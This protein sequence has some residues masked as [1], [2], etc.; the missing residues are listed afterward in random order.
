VALNG[1][2][3][4][5]LVALD[6]V[7]GATAAHVRRAADNRPVLRALAACALQAAA[8]ARRS[9]DRTSASGRTGLFAARPAQSRTALGA[10]P[11]GAGSVDAQL[12][13]HLAGARRRVQHRGSDAAHA[14]HLAS[15]L[16]LATNSQ[17]SS[18]TTGGARAAGRV[19][20]TPVQA[21]S[22]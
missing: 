12:A 17:R 9:A 15:A 20:A 7:H 3:L 13:E 5:S 11:S 19:V 18:P 4:A 14:L 21:A 8:D 6:A 1:R 10:G 2:L 16:L 22:S